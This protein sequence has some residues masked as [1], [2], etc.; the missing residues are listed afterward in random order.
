MEKALIL[1]ILWNQ[2]DGSQVEIVAA[3]NLTFAECDAAQRSVWRMPQEIAGHDAQGAFPVIDAAC[4][5]PAQLS[6]D[7]D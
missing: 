1:L 3:R 2:P 5:Y 4:V 7:S 6:A